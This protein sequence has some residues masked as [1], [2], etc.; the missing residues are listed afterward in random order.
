MIRD[1]LATVLAAALLPG[2]VSAAPLALDFVPPPIAVGDVCQRLPLLETESA[3]GTAQAD[4]TLTDAL[5]VQ[6]LISDTRRAL[7]DAAETQFTF[8]ERMIAERERLDPRFDAVEAALAR[9]SLYLRA[10]RLDALRDAGLVPQLLGQAE[11]LNN[12]QLARLAIFVRDGIGIDADRAQAHALLLEAAYGGH[13]LALLEIA[14]LQVRGALDIAWDAP[15]DLTVTMAFGGILGELSPGVCNR[16]EQIAQ[17]YLKGEVVVRNPG[18]AL[19]W[20]RFAADLGSAEAAWRVVEHHLNTPPATR[21]RDELKIYLARAV[22]LGLELDGARAERVLTSGAVTRSEIA[23]MRGAD[24][25]VGP[26]SLIPHLAL[27]VTQE[28]TRAGSDDPRRLYLKEIAHWPEAPG[29]V[30]TE[31]A[32]LELEE[33]GRWAGEAEARILLEEAARRGDPEGMQRL[34]QILTRYRTEPQS[35]ALAETLLMETVSRHGNAAS[36]QQLDGLYRCQVPDAPRRNAANR[37]AARYAATRAPGLGLRANDVLTLD[38]STHPEIIATLQTQAMLSRPQ[39][40][41]GLAARTERDAHVTQA[42]LRFWAERME[43]SPQ[44]LEAFAELGFEL[45]AT[46]QARDAAVDFFRRVQLNNGVTTA[47]DLAVALAEHNGRDPV[48]AEET[49]DLLRMAAQRGEGAAIRLLS[50]L[51]AADL[52]PEGYAGRAADV[53]SDY[54]DIIEERGDFLA[55]M[56]AL[57][58]VPPRTFDDYV[59]RAVSLMTCGTKDVQELA[60]AHAMRGEAAMALHWQRVGLSLDGG[61][62]LSKLSLTDAQMARFD[63][64]AAPSAR[65]AAT[66]AAALGDQAAQRRLYLLSSDPGLPGY[67]PEAAARHLLE[68][69]A[70]DGERALPWLLRAFREAPREIQ[71]RVSAEVDIASIYRRAAEGG[72]A[73]AAYQYALLLRD[74]GDAPNTLRESLAFLEQAADAGHHPAMTEL[75]VALGLGLGTAQD[76]EGALAW[77]DRASDYGAANAAG[78]AALIRRAG[79]P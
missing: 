70:Q 4:G 72:D 32:R 25:A 68:V 53:Y 37:W 56:F 75:A 21:N 10:G 45:S 23:W 9:I 18:V 17:E 8:I 76:V 16:A 14:R 39:A 42:A 77:L 55:L 33:R 15:L 79:Q 19:A 1:K 29:R 7:R 71:T 34:A 51:Q 78:L 73:D 44:A 31:L 22:E 13:A 28:S 66:R 11:G 59:D 61:S 2:S 30:F 47:L 62:V 27:D 54:A 63:A 35:I 52:S 58:F 67:D 40:L 43:R 57:P 48:I 38:P 26:T 3:G 12:H 20:R 74:R 60:D 41:A 65:Q 64:G 69:A 49:L 24:T 46:A 36:M 50:R 5:R 6:Y